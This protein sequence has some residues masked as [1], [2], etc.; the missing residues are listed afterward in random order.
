MVPTVTP[1]SNQFTTL[2]GAAVTIRFTITNG[3]PDIEGER[4]RWYFED[5]EIVSDATNYTISR[6]SLSLTVHNPQISSAGR[7]RVAVTN[8]AGTS[9]GRVML[10][11]YGM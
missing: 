8:A 7:Y 4:T 6:D 9:E 11:V 2:R 1:T 10:K 3:F 5:T